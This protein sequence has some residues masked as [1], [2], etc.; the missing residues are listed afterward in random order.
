M[1][2]DKNGVSN[3]WCGE[4]IRFEEKKTIEYSLLERLFAIGLLWIYLVQ[5]FYWLFP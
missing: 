3:E 5:F 1:K 4:H 2:I